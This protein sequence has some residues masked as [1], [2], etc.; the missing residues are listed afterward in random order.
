MR[1]QK[2]KKRKGSEEANEEGKKN[3]DL[4]LEMVK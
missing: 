1:K 2:Y 4:E 3:G